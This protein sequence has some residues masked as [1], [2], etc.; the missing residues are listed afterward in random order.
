MSNH[1]DDSKY[2]VRN[3]NEVIA[4]L[5]CLKKERVAIKLSTSHGEECNT[6][7]LSVS[8][9]QNLVFMDISCDE[10]I[11]TKVA[12]RNHVTF[13]TKTGIQVRW[14]SKNV[15]LVNL[16]DGIAFSIRIPEVLQRIQRRE[17]FRFPIHKKLVC[18]K[19]LPTVKIEAQVKNISAGGVG[20]VLDKPLNPVCSQ[21]SL[22][23][24]CDIDLSA[25]GVVHFKLKICHAWAI[26][27]TR[28]GYNMCLGMEF[29]DMNRGTNIAMQR[30]LMQIGSKK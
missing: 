29:V 20:V 6:Y 11:N 8:A 22:L 17:H 23:D 5:E 10:K 28:S 13:S 30:Y 3:R 25:I 21:G 14:H 16:P 4:I 27:N 18:R 9:K 24:Y 15:S 12:N 19:L 7:V 2:S 26:T 1:I